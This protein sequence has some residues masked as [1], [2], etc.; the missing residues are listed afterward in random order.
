MDCGFSFFVLGSGVFGFPV[1]FEG[2]FCVW[3]GSGVGGC[4]CGC[5]GG[6]VWCCAGGGG[7]GGWVCGVLVLCRWVGLVVWRLQVVGC[8]WWG[9]MGRMSR[10][11]CLVVWVMLC[12]GVWGGLGVR[13]GGRVSWRAGRLGCLVVWWVVVLGVLIRGGRGWWIVR[14]IR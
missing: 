9:R 8:L 7:L 2:G 5:G 12:R 14:R 10:W 13:G 3:C 4:G 11:W 1:T 6:G